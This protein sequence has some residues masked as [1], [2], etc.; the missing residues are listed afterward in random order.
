MEVDVKVFVYFCSKNNCNKNNNECKS[1][2]TGAEPDPDEGNATN[3]KLSLFALTVAIF[4]SLVKK[5]E[6]WQRWSMLVYE[7]IILKA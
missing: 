4:T 3:L 1:G 2:G 5:N 6:N 7:F